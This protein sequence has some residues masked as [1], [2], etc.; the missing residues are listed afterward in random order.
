[1]LIAPV[2][3]LVSNDGEFAISVHSDREDNHVTRLVIV[4]CRYDGTFTLE[5][6]LIAI[7][8]YFA[9]Q[10]KGCCK[11]FLLTVLHLLHTVID[12]EVL[13]SCAACGMDFLTVLLVGVILMEL[14]R[15]KVD[16]CQCS[17]P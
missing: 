3:L 10:M 17:L 1:M 11:L 14:H 4:V 5:V 15:H 13:Q 16:G 12:G 6:P 9:M 7:I 8:H 2:A